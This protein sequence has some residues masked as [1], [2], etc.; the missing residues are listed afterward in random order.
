MD[1]VIHLLN[2]RGLDNKLKLEATCQNLVASQP[3]SAAYCANSQYAKLRHL[4]SCETADRRS[5]SKVSFYQREEAK[6]PDSRILACEQLQKVCEHE[7][8]SNFL[9][10]IRAMAQ[11]ASTFI[12]NGTIRYP[13]LF[14][15]WYGLIK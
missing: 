7:Q 8:T 12:L 15:P 9:R 3:I 6:L 13:Y 2:N 5:R 11:F 14:C 10:A 1:S 4:A